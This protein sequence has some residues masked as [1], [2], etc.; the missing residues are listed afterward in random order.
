MSG[1]MQNAN[2]VSK[3]INNNRT[4]NLNINLSNGQNGRSMMQETVGLV[5][6][7]DS[8]YGG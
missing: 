5:N 1:F 3:T 8:V 4:N 6:L 2:N 7:L